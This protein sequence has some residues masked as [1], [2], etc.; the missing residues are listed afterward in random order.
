MHFLDDTGPRGMSRPTIVCVPGT[1]DRMPGHWQEL[2]CEQVPNAR[3][4]PPVQENKLSL[5][6]RVENLDRTLAG[7]DGPVVLVAHSAGT[8]ITAHWAARHRRDS[9]K[10]ALLAAPVDLETPLPGGSPTLDELRAEGWLPL[11][12]QPLWFPSIVAAS[13]N[14]GLGPL[15]RVKALASAWGSRLVNL[16]DVGHLS[17]ANGYGSWPQ[18]MKFIDELSGLE[19]A[20]P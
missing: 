16:G 9:V 15:E 13:A 1:R 10:G 7:V 2:L 11:P 14:D 8:I 19:R 12:R 20:T 4:V 5:A 17:P 3:I 18:A 6:A